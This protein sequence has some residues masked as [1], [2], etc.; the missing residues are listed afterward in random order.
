MSSIYPF[1][2]KYT[3]N[4][5]GGIEIT[6]ICG[7]HSTQGNIY[8]S[9]ILISENTGNIIMNYSTMEVENDLTLSSDGYINSYQ[10]SFSMQSLV[11]NEK[12]QT[13]VF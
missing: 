3:L 1:I 13:S 5:N 8:S 11:L 6:N 2:E 4:A 9:Y 12:S 10:D 7:L